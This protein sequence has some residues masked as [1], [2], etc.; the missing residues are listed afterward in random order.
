M[1]ARAILGRML[2]SVTEEAPARRRGGRDPKRDTREEI[3]NAAQA[4]WQR[5]GY[6]A[7]SYHH[8]AVQLGIR[9]AAI[10]YHFP[11][12]ENLGVALI[13]RYRERFAEWF[14]QARGSDNARERL[15]AWFQLYLDYVNAE[16]QVC[17][18]GILGTEFHAIPEEMRV[19]AKELMREIYEWLIETLTL[20]RAQDTL[21]YCGTPEDKAVQLGAA[22]QGGLQIARVAGA[23]RFDQLLAQLTLELTGCPPAG[24]SS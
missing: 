12:K 11:S 24:A 3:L 6:N 10:H 18:A 8:I 22:L 16:C 14:V 17:P 9:N 15:H 7:F 20:G 13:R 5:R 21:R 23:E 4:L 19:E 1:E 2:S